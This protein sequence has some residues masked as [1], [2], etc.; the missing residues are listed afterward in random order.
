MTATPQPVK[1]DAGVT[2]TFAHDHL[3]QLATSSSRADTAIVTLSGIGIG[4]IG[5]LAQN[6]PDFEYL[7]GSRMLAVMLALGALAL[8]LVTLLH[9]AFSRPTPTNRSLIDVWSVAAHTSQHFS[10]RYRSV[11]AATLLQDLTTQIYHQSGVVAAKQNALRNAF[12]ALT[13]AAP[14]WAFAVGLFA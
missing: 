14:A 7:E 1:T 10:E 5:Y 4:M 9:V 13:V 3:V 2:A 11:D 8:E 12:T 6:S